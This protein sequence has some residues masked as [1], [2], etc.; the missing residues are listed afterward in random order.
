[1]K[2]DSNFE[3][4]DTFRFLVD[5]TEIMTLVNE[6]ISKKSFV[7]RLLEKICRG[8]FSPKLPVQVVI[9]VKKLVYGV[10]SKWS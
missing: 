6:G 4:E 1:M 7:K 8:T 9:V 2:N 3:L 10:K 5:F